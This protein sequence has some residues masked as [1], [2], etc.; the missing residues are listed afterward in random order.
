MGSAFTE[1]EKEEIQSALKKAARHCAATLGMR[2]TTVDQLAESAGISKGAFYNFYQTK[3]HLFFEILEDWHSEVYDA[4]WKMWLKRSDLPNPDRVAEALLE[5][6]R[7]ME[8]NSMTGFF[9][10]DLPALL[11]KIPKE[12]LKRHYHSDTVHIDELMKRSGVRLKVS[13]AVFSAVVRGLMMTLAHRSQIGDAYPQA[14]GILIK[15][16]CDQ[17]ICS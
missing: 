11:R 5:A 2:K 3:E 13:P 4:A 15:G 7:V 14:F 12:D 16:A 6:C 8:N 17:M 9:E 10:N 1:Q